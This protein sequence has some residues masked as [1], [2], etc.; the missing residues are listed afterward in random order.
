MRWHIKENKRRIEC[1]DFKG[2]KD[3]IEMT[4]EKVSM[5]IT[6]EVDALGYLSIKRKLIYPLFRIQP[7]ITTSS[8]QI[9][10]SEKTIDFGK[11][12]F[13][14]VEIDGTLSIYSETNDFNI[15]HIFY[16]SVKYA[17]AY[18]KIIIEKK[19]NKRIPHFD[20]LKR[21]NS[22]LGCEG[23]IYTD[24]IATKKD[25]SITFSLILDFL[26]NQL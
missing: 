9:D 16:P 4:G 26:M 23:W 24:R 11:E 20:K 8:Y 7:D 10:Y 13:V 2:H 12:K 6:Y 18:E 22:T 5:I 21:I 1:F 25:N 19:K 17:C 3:D 14:K 15:I